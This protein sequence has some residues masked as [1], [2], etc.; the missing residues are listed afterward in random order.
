LRRMHGIVAAWEQ[1]AME[2]APAWMQPMVA[3][4]RRIHLLERDLAWFGVN[5]LDER[6][7]KLPEMNDLATLFGAMY[8]IEG[9]TLGGQLIAR[10]VERSLALNEGQGDAYFRGYLDRT[11]EMWKDFCSQL[12]TR[13]PEEQT[14]N[15]VEAAKA[16]FE[17]YG[18]WMREKSVM[19]GT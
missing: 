4:R 6:R 15:V 2:I 10:S 9:S 7:P 1:R 16:M 11:G 12:T 14:D 5:D 17:T 18:E 19:D 8:V 13:V 3:A